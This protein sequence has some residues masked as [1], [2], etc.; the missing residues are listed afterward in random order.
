MRKLFEKQLKYSEGKMFLITIIATTL[1]GLINIVI[2]YTTA[3]GIVNE[4]GSSIVWVYIGVPVSAI[5]LELFY[6]VACAIITYFT[7]AAMQ[8]GFDIKI[9]FKLAYRILISLP[10]ITLADMVGFIVLENKFTDYGL[11]GILSYLPFYACLFLSTYYLAP[12]YV[13]LNKKQS[14]AMAIVLTVGM[15]FISYPYKF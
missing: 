8:K 3:E 14:M 5:I 15:I 11:I 4:A 2:N 7:A 1:L 10:L 6:S 13:E 12:K 9:F